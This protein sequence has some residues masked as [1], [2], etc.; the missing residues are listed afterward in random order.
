[1][2]ARHLLLALLLLPT[3]P[4][5]GQTAGTPAPFALETKIPLGPVKG[6]IDHLAVDL[7]RKLLFVAE[8]GNNS[9]GVVDLADG[10]VRRTIPGFNEPQ[11]IG[12]EPYSDTVYVANGGDG[13]VGVLRAGDSTPLGRIEL[14]DD[15]DN[16]RIDMKQQHVVVGYGKGGLALIE[17]AGRHKIADIKV[18][19]HPEG[20][21]L[22]EAAG[23]AWVN[24]PG[25]GL[26]EVVD[27]AS[28]AAIGTLPTN[29]YSGNYPMALDRP[30]QRVLVVFRRPAHLLVTAI[31]RTTVLADLDTCGDADDLFVDPKRRRV[32][33][34]CGTGVVDVFEDKDDR[35]QRAGRF[36][37]S[38]GAWTGLF[39]PELDRLYV[40]VRATG[41]E[42][43]AIWTLRPR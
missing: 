24:L 35:Y 8:L 3:L 40:A 32:Y 13:S 20:F 25:A 30:A 22:N 34:I 16:V 17:P 31:A 14:G 10:S 39:V 18:K 27:L 28:G 15:A 36:P 37:T 26:I 41:S 43:A 23:Q 11:G 6:R 2:W 7:K 4:A 38:P 19:A 21:Q 12:V 33:V 5:L 29:G 42:P 9:I 1:M